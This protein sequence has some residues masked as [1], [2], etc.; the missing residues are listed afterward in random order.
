LAV[1][2]G[3]PVEGIGASFL[4]RGAIAERGRKTLSA[5]TTQSAE[6]LYEVGVEVVRVF[7]A[8]GKAKKIARAGRIRPFDRGAMFDQTLHP[9]ERRRAFPDAQTAR[10]GDRGFFPAGNANGKHG[11]EASLH[12]ARGN[13]VSREFLKS[14]VKHLHNLCIR[15]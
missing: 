13:I 9:A 1:L 15:A 10:R 6:C 8:D 11:S 3:G 4:P 7:N 5:I 12:L 14:G 2:V